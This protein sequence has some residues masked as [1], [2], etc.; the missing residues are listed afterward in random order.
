MPKVDPKTTIDKDIV[1]LIMWPQFFY[2]QQAQFVRDEAWQ[3]WFIGGNG[4]GKTLMLYWSIC[5]YLA[6][7]HPH[8]NPTLYPDNTFPLPPLKCRIIV[9]SFDNVE[10]VA[11]D[12]LLNPQIVVFEK[13]GE[14]KQIEMDPLLPKSMLKPKSKF[15]KERR[16]LNWR[17]GS[18]MNWV[19]SEQGWQFMRGSQFDILGVDEECDE[20]VFDENLRGLR[21]AKG[22]GKVIAALTPPYQAGHG[23]TWTKDKIVESSVEDQDISVINACM[24]DNPAITAKFIERF[25]K[26]KTRS[27][28]DVQVYGK[29][30]AWGDVVHPAFD[31]TIWDSKKVTGHILPNDTPMPDI[32]DVDWVMAFDWHQSKPCAAVWAFIKRDGTFVV[33]DELD[34]EWAKNKEISDLANAF[35][36]IEGA[37]HVK[38]KFRRWQDPSAKHSYDTRN[39]WDAF[40]AEGII[41]SAGKNR[42]P[43]IGINIVNEYIRGNGSDHPRMFI[44]ER[45]RYTRQYMGNHYWKRDATG[46]GKPDPK[47]S[48]YPICI[49]YILGEVGWKS[50]HRQKKWPL[51]SYQ[52]PKTTRQ[53]INLEGF[54]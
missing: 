21:N 20:R 40:R 18:Q 17:N 7:I 3:R 29:Y 30:P 25:S 28:I 1:P 35:E 32:W 46:K 49:R 5:A 4:T 24:A 53:S 48:D 19:T 14:T 52:T 50:K 11:L 44:Y 2:R 9:P 22:G 23:P 12:K 36:S 10:D 41:T 37:P 45:C 47:W 26:G 38:R 6:G 42:D 54:F 15:T 33:F 27:Q 8:Q 34:K 13:D 51:N 39:A 43:D 31:D 16:Y